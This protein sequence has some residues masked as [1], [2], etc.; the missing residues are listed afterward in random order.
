MS[1]TVNL[2]YTG[3][4]GN[5]LKFVKEME[6][7]GIAAAIRA[8]DGNV[9]Y[10]YFQSLADPETVLLIDAWH[11]QKALDDHH[12]SPMMGQL[13]ALRDKYDLHMR[14]ERYVTAEDYAADH[15]FIRQ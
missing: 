14:V 1:L 3:E 7:S 11:D 9:K 6:E 15:Q 5:A 2:Y 13:A 12:A 8:E 10:N 4:N